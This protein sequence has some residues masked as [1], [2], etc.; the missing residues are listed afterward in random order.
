MVY[1][2]RLK[3]LLQ[4]KVMFG[5]THWEVGDD[6]FELNFG[7][8]VWSRCHFYCACKNLLSIKQNR[9]LAKMSSLITPP[10]IVPNV[11]NPLIRIWGKISLYISAIAKVATIIQARRILGLMIKRWMCKLQL[12]LGTCCKLEGNL[13][14]WCNY[15]LHVFTNNL[16]FFVM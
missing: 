8:V 10:I 13:R 15:C 11:P 12:L 5:C 3:K 4:F 9:S 7:K 16:Q 6:S 2:T 1:D 14:S